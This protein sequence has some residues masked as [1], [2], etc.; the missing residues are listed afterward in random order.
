MKDLSA[1]RPI[2]HSEADFQHALAWSIHKTFPDADVRLEFPLEVGGRQF[3]VDIWVSRPGA[4]LA[5]ELKYKTRRLTT[6]IAQESFRLKDQAAQDLARY[7]FFKDVY[8]LEQVS[9]KSPTT[10]G[11]AIFLTNDSAYWNRPTRQAP[12]DAQFRIHEGRIAS[13]TLTW[14]V[15]AS[16]GTVRG[17]EEPIRLA[18]DYRLAW[19][20]YSKVP[21]RSYGVLRF[22]VL[23]V[24]KPVIEAA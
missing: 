20:D 5:V 22:L 18:A 6:R 10:T 21:S 8:R 16:A 14:G 3:H 15:G 2:F 4:S 23:D 11:L 24:A 7:D 9:R 12:V 13:G 17:R 19:I 1:Q